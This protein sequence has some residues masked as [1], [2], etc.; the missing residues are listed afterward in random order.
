VS[1]IPRRLRG[2]AARPA[3]LLAAIALVLA[4]AVASPATAGAVTGYRALLGL[5]AQFMC[6]SCH[7]PLELVSSPQA[8]AEKGT[9]A[10]L[11]AAGDSTSEIRSAMVAQYGV[12]VLAKPPASGFNLALYVL[13]PALLLLG[14]AALLYTLPKWRAR[15][16][17]AALTQ[18][19]GAPPLA[20]GDAQRIDDEL[21]RF[22]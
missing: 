8:Q 18:L 1:A 7:E 12:Q 20:A 21:A 15:A 6:L 16:R 22:I 14:A 19:P 2:R 13:P 4:P 11:L 5:E 9:I 10:R 17:R 3:A